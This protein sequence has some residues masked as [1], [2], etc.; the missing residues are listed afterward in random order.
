[1]LASDEA[2]VKVSGSAFIGS[3][4]KFVC[5]HISSQVLRVTSSETFVGSLT[6]LQLVL[7]LSASECFGI[8]FL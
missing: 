8:C 4:P 5:F 3:H 1:M 7:C 2:T 6:I